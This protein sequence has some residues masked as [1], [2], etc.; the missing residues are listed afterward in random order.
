[1][2]DLLGAVG[3]FRTLQR[4]RGFGAEA[5]NDTE[6]LRAG[7]AVPGLP[8][9]EDQSQQRLALLN[10]MADSG[11]QETAFGLSGL[12]NAAALP[13]YEGIKGLDQN[14]GTDILGVLEH[15]GLDR[16]TGANA[17]TTPASIPNAIAGA[18]GPA[19]SATN[20]IGSF[21]R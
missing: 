16:V 7:N 20:R 8:G 10:R 5:Y 9:F 15:A 21:F 12:F 2:A 19:L 1:M 14:M 18:I 3:D 6:A 4:E 13:I 17:Q 11:D